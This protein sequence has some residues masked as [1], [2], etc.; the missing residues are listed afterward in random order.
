MRI[1]A[2]SEPCRSYTA[3]ARALVWVLVIG[4]VYVATFGSAHSHGN[5]S[6]KL[7]TNSAGSAAEQAGPSFTAPVHKHSYTHECLVC[8]LRQQFSNS[9]FP[10][11]LFIDS[12]RQVASI[13]AP[14]VFCYSLSLASN[15][16]TCLSGRGPPLCQA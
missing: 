7:D 2:P 11:T 6:S 15:P 4:F 3:L 8:L 12:S 13:S 1:R 10:Q 9:I 5:V 14:T 16:V